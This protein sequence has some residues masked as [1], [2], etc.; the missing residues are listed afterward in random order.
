[1]SAR[2][3]T[4]PTDEQLAAIASTAVR[5]ADGSWLVPSSDGSKA[6]RVTG[7]G[8]SC[9]DFEHRGGFCKHR[10]AI[11]F[12]CPPAPLPKKFEGDPFQGF[13]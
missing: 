10:L 7:T 1:M 2:I 4:Q 11:G 9:P 5:Q 8:C 13:A 12:V 3:S 6:Y